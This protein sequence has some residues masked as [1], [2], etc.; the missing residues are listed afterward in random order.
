MPVGNDVVDLRDPHNQPAALHPRFDTRVFGHEERDAL[1][2]ASDVETRHHLRW[3]M[4]AAKESALKYLRQAEPA[5]PFH[6]REFAVHLGSSTIARVTHRGAELGVT[7]DVTPARVH[8][9]TLGAPG[10]GSAHPE[11]VARTGIARANSPA[12]ASAEVRRLAAREIACL[13]DVSPAGIEI[14]GSAS[15]TPRAHRDGEPL[16]I[17]LSLSHDGDWLAWAVRRSAAVGLGPDASCPKPGIRQTPRA[18]ALFAG[19]RRSAATLPP[20]SRP[21][22]R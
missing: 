22:C 15:S 4:W 6:P 16:P 19:I 5:L 21:T 2:A 18:F 9:V 3:T 7:L 12:D 1:A 10:T 14:D 11:A 8:A 20:G 13:L 17:E